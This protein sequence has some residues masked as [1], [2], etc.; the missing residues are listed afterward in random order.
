MQPDNLPN[1]TGSNNPWDSKAG[2]KRYGK[3]REI[4]TAKIEELISRVD[5]LLEE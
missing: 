1:Y 5:R 3:M 2:F 4:D